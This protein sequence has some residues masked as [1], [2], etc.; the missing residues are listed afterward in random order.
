MEAGAPRRGPAPT[1]IARPQAVASPCV[2][3]AP[4]PSLQTGTVAQFTSRQDV[5][6]W[7]NAHRKRPIVLTAHGT[8]LRVNGTEGGTE[9]LDA[10]SAEF[11]Q[12]ELDVGV[13]GVQV[14]LT[15][16]DA[17]V[18]LQAI[19]LQGERTVC[20]LPVSI[21]Y[22]DLRLRVAEPRKADLASAADGAEE[23]TDYSPYELLHRGSD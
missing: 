6:A 4:I 2:A 16:H 18:G 22:A 19:V 3:V 9:E 15:L 13:P 23:E 11:V 7:F 17:Q 12:V 14:A 20:S 8:Q 21:A 1:P 10:C 5:V